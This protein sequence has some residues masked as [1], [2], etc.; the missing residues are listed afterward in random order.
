MIRPTCPICGTRR[1]S[2]ETLSDA[3]TRLGGTNRWAVLASRT[4]AASVWS[5]Y[6]THTQT[7]PTYAEAMDAAHW[8]A[9]ADHIAHAHLGTA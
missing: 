3:A 9:V 4:G 8:S 2:S 6:G 5:P 1:H 7:F